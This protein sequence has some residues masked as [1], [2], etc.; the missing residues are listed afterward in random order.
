MGGKYKLIG[1][2]VPYSMEAVVC[3]T[4]KVK[5]PESC[6]SHSF[7]PYFL[8]RCFY[9][10]VCYVNLQHYVPLNDFATNV[11]EQM[12]WVVDHDDEAQRISE[13]AT[14]WMED[15]VFH[16]D[17]DEDDRLIQEMIL[18]RYQSHF[19]LEK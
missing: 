13:R 11:E 4:D 3:T 14:L 1:G 19:I 8:S 12:Q 9:A 5:H 15:L 6:A 10:I 2:T 16:P 18:R 17:A 7:L